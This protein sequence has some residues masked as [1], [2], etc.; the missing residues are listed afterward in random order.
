MNSGVLQFSLGI[1]DAQFNSALARTQAAMAGVKNKTAAMASGLS[2]AG[3]AMLGMRSRTEVLRH[4]LD[5]LGGNFGVLGGLSR[6]MLDPMTIGFAAVFGV[7]TVINRELEKGQERMRNFLKETGKAND[8]LK[9]IV[10]ARPTNTDEWTELVKLITKASEKPADIKSF[11]EGIIGVQKGTD[12][13]KADAAQEQLD[14]EQKKIELLREQRKISAADAAKRIEALKNQAVLQKN[15]DERTSIQHEIKTRQA[16]LRHVQELAAATPMPQALERKQKADARVDD[17]QNQLKGL[18]GAIVKNKELTDQAQRNFL[19]TGDKTYLNAFENSRDR[20]SRLEDKL[21]F[22]KSAFP[23]AAQEASDA[24]V[25]VENA[26]NYKSRGTELQG[27]IVG[28]QNKL[29]VTVD[30]QNKL[31]PLELEKNRL[32]AIKK[33]EP[34]NHYKPEATSIEKMGFVMGG[35]SSPI[36]ELNRRTA[37]ATEKSVMALNKI[38][39]LLGG[40]SPAGATNQI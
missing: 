33:T 23:G 31:T 11:G 18:P 21:G 24:N 29:G 32:D 40:G 30:R 38:V 6:M 16:D 17:L 22:A 20:G 4:S 27:N 14:L 7:M 10:S 15:L 1:K 25:G 28:L 9:G 26:K 39:D 36:L 37:S 34:E 35:G 3:G 2:D 13:N 8:F 5:A 19:K 12:E